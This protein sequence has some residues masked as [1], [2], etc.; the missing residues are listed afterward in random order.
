MSN[1]V[2]SPAEHEQL[3]PVQERFRAERLE[4]ESVLSH[5]EISRS[6]AA[7]RFLT[8]I[9]DKYFEGRSEEIREYSIAVEALGRH[10]VNYLSRSKRVANRCLGGCPGP[11]AGMIGRKEA[12]RY[13]PPWLFT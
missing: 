11:R 7:V 3:Q 12:S 8:F 13:R 2:V 6:A 10:E 1:G 9:C 5:P 4:L